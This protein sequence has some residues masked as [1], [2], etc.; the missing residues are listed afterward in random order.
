MS[1]LDRWAERHA[2]RLLPELIKDN[3]LHLPI[4]ACDDLQRCKPRHRGPVLLR[5]PGIANKQGR[6]SYRLALPVKRLPSKRAL[7]K[8]QDGFRGLVHQAVRITIRLETASSND[9]LAF[10]AGQKALQIAGAY[11][12]Q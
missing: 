9:P 2:G 3:P 4:F 5:L 8:I 10:S 1:D 12:T 11:S 6:L 7:A